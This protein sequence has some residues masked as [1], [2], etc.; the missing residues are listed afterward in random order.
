[1]G[2]LVNTIQPEKME[3]LLL[4][5]TTTLILLM[6]SPN[7]LHACNSATVSSNARPL[8]SLTGIA[9]TVD[10]TIGSTLGDQKSCPPLYSCR[11]G[12]KCCFRRPRI[13]RCDYEDCMQ[14]ESHLETKTEI[15]QAMQD[16]ESQDTDS[17]LR[18]RRH[19]GQAK[20]LF[21]LH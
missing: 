11:L 7:G 2:S 10:V 13:W 8:S 18:K 6:T 5:K 14:M 17:M 15:G 19:P 16:K 9:G 4:L 20:S 21:R 12:N 1:M 3:Q